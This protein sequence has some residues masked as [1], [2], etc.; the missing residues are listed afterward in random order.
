MHV[1]S[2]CH[3]TCRCA[4]GFNTSKTAIWLV[5]VFLIVGVGVVSLR[6]LPHALFE[7]ELELDL[8]LG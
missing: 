4:S 7:L 8:K 2:H 5:Y 1:I 6:R 3:F